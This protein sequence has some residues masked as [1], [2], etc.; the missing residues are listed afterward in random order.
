MLASWRVEDLSVNL[1]HHDLLEV[2]LRNLPVLNRLLCALDSIRG[3]RV[4]SAGLLAATREFALRSLVIEQNFALEATIHGLCTL[5]HRGCPDQMMARGL[6]MSDN[7]PLI[8][9]TAAA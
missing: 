4:L 8:A 2:L 1:F 3:E 7:L 6:L 5:V 9:V